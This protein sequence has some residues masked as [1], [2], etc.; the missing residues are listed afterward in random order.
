MEYRLVETAAPN[1][2]NAPTSALSITVSASAVT[3]LQSGNVAE[4]CKKGDAHWVPGQGD[5]TWQVRVWNSS[6]HKLPSTG[7][8]GTWPFALAGALLAFAG[9]GMLIRARRMDR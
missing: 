4:V 6:G 1:G 8:S 9:L 7:G 5:G 3:A 2:Y